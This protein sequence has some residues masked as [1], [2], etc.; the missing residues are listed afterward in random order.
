MLM[1]YSELKEIMRLLEL[2][3]IKKVHS[4]PLYQMR[5]TTYHL[6]IEYGASR[7]FDTYTILHAEDLK[8][9]LEYTSKQ[10]ELGIENQIIKGYLK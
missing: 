6:G 4:M 7:T 9:M 3:G 1:K 10:L 2:Y 8:G 5:K